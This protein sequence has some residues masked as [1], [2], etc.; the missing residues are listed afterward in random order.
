[1]ALK[2]MLKAL[3]RYLP[4]DVSINQAYDRQSWQV[5][6]KVCDQ[7]ACCVDVGCHKGEIMDWFIQRSPKGKHWG[8]EPIPDMYDKL[9]LKYQNN[10]N[11]TIYP[12]ALSETNGTTTFNLVVTNPAYSG[13]VKRNYDHANEKDQTIEVEM[14]TLDEL[15]AAVNKIDLIKI[16]VEGAELQVLKGA[17][18][19]LARTK[20]TVIFE[21]GLGASDCYGTQPADVFQFFQELNYSLNTM[22]NWLKN[23]PPLSKE[24]F[25]QQF[26]QKLNFYFIALP[27]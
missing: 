19:T 15:L 10:R 12:Y 24:A 5:I 13:M 25:E 7:N 8:F 1:M 11:I 27:Y 20:P 9:V 22:E 3:F 18:K 17:A 16:D 6:K 4:F 2:S 23:L 14:R 26:Y 21:H